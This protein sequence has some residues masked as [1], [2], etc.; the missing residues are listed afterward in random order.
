S[1][2]NFESRTPTA[3]GEARTFM[4]F[5]WAGGGAFAPQGNNPLTSTDN[6]VPRLRY[7][8]GT[9][10]GFLAG[11]ANSNFADPDADSPQQEF[12]G[13]VGNPG[14]TRIPQVRYTQPLSPY[15]LLGALSVSAEA[16]ET[17]SWTGGQ[18]QVASDTAAVT[19]TANPA[20]AC[21]SSAAVAGV[22][23]TVTCSLPG[24]LPAVN[25]TKSP[26]PDFT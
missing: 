21:T 9:L 5:D 16:P 13:Q 19:T 24:N 12:G 1:K 25:P 6:L 7:A 8:Y 17:D 15:G 23:P 3:Y 11:Q 26:M 10:G 22:A 14:V 18:G 20:L 2:V 4:E